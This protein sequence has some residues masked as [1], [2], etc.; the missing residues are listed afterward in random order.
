MNV[1]SLKITRQIGL[2]S[3]STSFN[4]LASTINPKQTLVLYLPIIQA[5]AH[6]LDKLNTVVMHVAESLQQEHVV[7]TVD[8]T[9][10]LIKAAGAEVISGSIQECYHTQPR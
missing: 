3:Q 9:L 8:E 6:E 10:Y 5:P 1:H 7:L 2:L 4:Q